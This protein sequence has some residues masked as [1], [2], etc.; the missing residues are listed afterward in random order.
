MKAQRH[1]SP[2]NLTRCVYSVGLSPGGSRVRKLGKSS[3]AIQKTESGEPG[4]TYN[5]ARC[6]DPGCD[7]GAKRRKRQCFRIIQ[8]TEAAVAEQETLWA[9]SV[10]V[11]AHDLTGVIDP[12][13]ERAGAG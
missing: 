7:G 8:G 3:A 1:E 5:L 12:M 10:V 11:L 6:V 4:I 9:F 13:S 2:D